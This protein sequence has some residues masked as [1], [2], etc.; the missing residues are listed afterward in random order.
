MSLSE[1]K[2]DFQKVTSVPSDVTP[3]LNLFQFIH[4]LDIR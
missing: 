1:V 2:G 4:N 3:E